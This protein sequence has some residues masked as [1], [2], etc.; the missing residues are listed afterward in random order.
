MYFKC[1]TC[2]YKY[3]FITSYI[4]AKCLICGSNPISFT[5]KDTETDLFR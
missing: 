4:N 2:G 5:E 1:K 3:N